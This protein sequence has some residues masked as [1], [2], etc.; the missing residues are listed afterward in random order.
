MRNREH[1]FARKNSVAFGR[2]AEGGGRPAHCSEPG[3]SR[4]LPG[5]VRPGSGADLPQS[6][7]GRQA[8]LEAGGPSLETLLKLRHGHWL[9]YGVEEALGA[10]G[11]K[12][13]SQLRVS[14]RH[15]KVP[16][17]AHLDLVLPDEDGRSLTVLELK[18]TAKLPGQVYPNHEAQLYG[19]LGPLSRL[20]N[21]PD[22][23]IG[24]YSASHTFPELAERHLGIKL[25]KSA[26]SVSIRGFVLAVSPQA[27]RAFGPHEPNAA[28]LTAMLRTGAVI[29]RH[30]AAIRSGQTT[31]EDVPHCSGVQS[32]CTYCAY[33]R[34]CPK[35]QGDSHP[36]LEQELATLVDLKAARSDLEAEIKERE[37]QLKALAAL[38]GRP[39][40]WING[41]THR[42]RIS[43]Q[44]G[45]VTLDH[46]LLKSG[47][48]QGDG[49]DEK[50][51]SAMLA[52]AQKVG[53]PFER[54]QI[55]PINGFSA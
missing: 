55:S 17:K 45:K 26:A 54:L 3:G 18:S 44:A 31:L 4:P 39:G 11:R 23:S 46:N 10:A 37:A 7:R 30:L 47:L 24:D 15:G 22:F 36:E 20:W 35:F 9:E 34:D 33:N 25:P 21:R 8:E 41:R 5:R 50:K 27:A 14:L 38:M 1:G 12:Y 40:Q 32:T 52:S 51:L 28:V 19:Q 13:I 49:M 2:R 42:F 29:W 6:R 48:E 16:V 53:R 43:S